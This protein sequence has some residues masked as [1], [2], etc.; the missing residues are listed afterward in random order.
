MSPFLQAFHEHVRPIPAPDE[1][2]VQ[3][4]LFGL[5][6]DLEKSAAIYFA[7]SA[8][9][10]LVAMALY[11]VSRRTPFFIH[12]AKSMEKSKV[13]ASLDGVP[14]SHLFFVECSC[15]FITLLLCG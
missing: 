1:G 13:G 11:M 3:S 15:L 9:L 10:M 6:T 2:G 12:Y 5:A 8:G 4:N 14:K 7:M